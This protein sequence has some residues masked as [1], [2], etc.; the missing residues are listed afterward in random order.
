[1]TALGGRRR[2][3]A[4]LL[5][6]VL[7]V[8]LLSSPVEAAPPADPQAGRDHDVIFGLTATQLSI[9]AGVGLGVGIAA[10]LVARSRLP[11]L[12]SRGALAGL[13]L[14]TLAGIYVAHLFV[15]AVLVGGVY[16]YWP[17]ERGPEDDPSRSMKLRI[18]PSPGAAP[19]APAPAQPRSSR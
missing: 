16:Y 7:A 13:G 3:T 1:M 12:V 2:I 5:P 14:G 17:S 4:G 15:E 19:E 11:A 6:A 8:L 10:A 18:D 9:A